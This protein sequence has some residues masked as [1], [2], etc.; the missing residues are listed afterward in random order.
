MTSTPSAERKVDAVARSIAAAMLAE[1]GSL[2]IWEDGVTVFDSYDNKTYDCR[3]IAIAAISAGSSE[4]DP[5]RRAEP[6]E[7]AAA[8]GAW[9]SRHGG[10]LGPGP[11]FVEAI[12][13][14]FAAR[15]DRFEE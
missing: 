15:K 6:E 8:W 7:I 5:L 9:H 14:A 3:N 11:A 4:L 2:E 12:N 1:N 10:K 13:A